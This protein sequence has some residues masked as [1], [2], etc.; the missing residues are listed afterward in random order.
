MFQYERKFRFRTVQLA[1]KVAQVRAAM[2]R[3]FLGFSNVLLRRLT[4][5]ITW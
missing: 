1:S 4:A 5:F 2:L 3:G